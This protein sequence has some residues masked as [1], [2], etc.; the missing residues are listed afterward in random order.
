MLFLI[1]IIIIEH[2]DM[3]FNGAISKEAPDLAMFQY[4]E[5]DENLHKKRRHKKVS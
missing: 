3:F 2:E 5:K 1:G 4:K